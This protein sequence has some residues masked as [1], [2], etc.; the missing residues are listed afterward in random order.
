MGIPYEV[1][2]DGYEKQFQLSH[3]GPFLLMNLLLPKMRGSVGG[4][5][6]VKIINVTSALQ[7]YG[8]IDFDN[9]NGK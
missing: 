8:K 1:T 6:T 9:L 3:L 5:R 2:G 4:E 7:Y